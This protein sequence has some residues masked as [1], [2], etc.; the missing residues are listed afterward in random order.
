MES[1]EEAQS[2]EPL[3]PSTQQKT[4][5]VNY[6]N[7]HAGFHVHIKTAR[8]T[9]P[10]TSDSTPGP[11]SG[12]RSP[13]LPLH[14]H[15]QK[16]DRAL[17]NAILTLDVF[18]PY[19][20]LRSICFRRAGKKHRKVASID[21]L[22]GLRALAFL[23][24]CMQHSIPKDIDK[25]EQ[26]LMFFLHYGN[27]GVSIFFV[28]SGFLIAHVIFQSLVRESKNQHHQ[29]RHRHQENH[30]DDRSTN[31]NDDREGGRIESSSASSSPPS[32]SPPS[33]SLSLTSH[34]CDFILG[35]V[36]RIFPAYI[37]SIL[38]NQFF[39]SYM[40]NN[41]TSPAPVLDSALNACHADGGLALVMLK[42]A[43]FLQNWVDD[44][45]VGC[46][47][48]MYSQAFHAPVCMYACL[49]R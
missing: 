39:F 31:H 32:Q 26:P 28:L 12:A 7:R 38:F 8:H 9:Y 20:H 41:K 18:N 46:R 48:G 35:R 45:W 22:D 15:P 21:M 5:R 11:S 17:S 27:F 16:K 36:F 34:Y 30:H 14:Q 42:H 25:H 6:R 4:E 1:D 2:R 47:G 13:A 33:S 29:D 3:L 19:L 49:C 40:H 24:V 44:G 43:L 37:V 23:C 10:S